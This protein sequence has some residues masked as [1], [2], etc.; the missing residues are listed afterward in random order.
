MI[1]RPP[2]PLGVRFE[3]FVSKPDGDTFGTACWLWTG[4]KARDG[5]GKIQLSQNDLRYGSCLTV[6]ATR[7]AWFLAAGAWPLPDQCVLHTCDNPSCV[8]PAHL[9]LGDHQSYMTDMVSKSRSA[10]L[11][12]HGGVVSNLQSALTKQ[13]SIGI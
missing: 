12:E 9:F 13:S 7:T 5:Y 2:V 10:V 11:G 1:G 3:R 4:C 8:N 6:R